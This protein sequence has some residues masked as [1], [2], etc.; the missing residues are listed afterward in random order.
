MVLR[1]FDVSIALLVLASMFHSDGSEHWARVGSC[2]YFSGGVDE[3]YTVG[4]ELQYVR[5]RN[6]GLINGRVIAECVEW[7]S[8][9]IG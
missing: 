9:R 3:C 2:M 7:W 1:P 6:L 4:D 5:I 8:L